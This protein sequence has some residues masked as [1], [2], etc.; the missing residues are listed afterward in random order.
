MKNITKFILIA[1]ILVPLSA[2]TYFNKEATETEKSDENKAKKKRIISANIDEKTQNASGSLFGSIGGNKSTTFQF[3]TSNVL[4]RAS[5]TSLEN[6]PLLNVD[7]SGGVIVTDWYSPKISNE[8]IKISI[9]F[10][11]NELKASSIKISS[12]KKKCSGVN[13]ATEKLPETFNS[14]IKET[15]IAKAK[16]IKL[17]D[18]TKKKN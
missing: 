1:I 14:K 12:F 7:Y 13:C 4:W 3:S 15:I 17:E 10:L 6:I 9:N 5:L 2:C 16:E 8:S 11:D 18:E